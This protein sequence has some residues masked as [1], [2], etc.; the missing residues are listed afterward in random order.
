MDN[1]PKIL[2]VGLP[3]AHGEIKGAF[4]NGYPIHKGFT[5]DSLNFATVYAH[6][7]KIIPDQKI[8]TR[9]H[10]NF[11]TTLRQAGFKLQVLP[12]PE[13]LNREDS[14]HHDG[15]F[16]R[17]SGFLFKKYWIKSNYSVKDRRPE[18]DAWAEI[19]KTRFHKTII[20]PPPGAYI[21]FGEVYY[22]KTAT[23]TYYFG[24]LS[25]SN[26]KGQRFVKSIVK[27]D[28]FILL[29]SHGYHLDTVMTPVINKDNELTALIITKNMF[30]EDSL[31]K[32]KNLKIPLITVGP[33]DSSGTG[34]KL[35]TYHV[36]CLPGPGVL[37]NTG[38]FLTPGVEDRLKALGIKRFYSP[39]TYFRYAGGSYHCLTNEINN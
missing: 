21:E 15:V 26:E 24:G 34:G 37:V 7:H 28:H 8:V 25:R 18:A 5:D 2:V 11:L 13:N 39:L 33:M 36:N 35:G 30:R 10:K 31:D 6:D 4:Y 3:K 17:D 29:H 16:I 32:L 27:P 22:F 38:K 19:I 14:L 9:D 1:F 12:F 20:T 23:S